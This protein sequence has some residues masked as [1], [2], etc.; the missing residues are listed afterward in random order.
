MKINKNA[1]RIISILKASGFQAVLAGGCV[2]DLLLGNSPKDWD[3]VTNAVP[4]KVEELFS[5]TVPVGKSFG[6]IVVIEGGEA[7]EVATFRAD[8]FST[9][10]DGRR[11]DSVSF[12]SMEEDAKRRDLTINGMFMDPMTGT[13]HDFV[14]GISDILSKTVRFIGD[15]I[16]RIKED[17][18]RMLRAVR[19]TAKFGFRLEESAL[20]A[21]R[22]CAEDIHKISNERIADELLKI[23]RTPAK[24]TQ[25]F[26]LLQTTRLLAQIL[27]EVEAM[28]G[29][30][31]P[32]EYHPEGDVFDH[33]MLALKNV[34]SDASDTLLLGTLLHDVGKPFTRTVEDRIRFSGHDAKGAEVA[35]QIL[36]RLRF[37]N[38]TIKQ[39]VSLV[40]NHIRWMFVKDMKK[41]KLKRFMQLDNFDEHKALHR[42]D[43]IS[44]H[45]NLSNLEFVNSV[46]FA[47]E[48]VKPK[49]LIGGQVL[50]DLGFKPGPDFK[51]ILTAVEDAQ[52]EG[53]ISSKE[54]AVDFVRDNF[55]K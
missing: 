27:P 37:P 39:V 54:S 9:L 21:L 19:F 29:C 25:A 45:E 32:V 28:I 24:A 8:N 22:I 11:P 2:R 13:I 15:P 6:V 18:L 46:K 43:C 44:S 35:E 1:K 42:V 55:V 34:P 41:S 23:L 38:N 14:N 7:F 31:Q 47:P 5:K 36:T 10:S 48:E 51:S 4:E 26:E 33:T 20:V 17:A 3:I 16:E 52:L 49:P 12:G 30:T 50:I 53:Q 40:Q